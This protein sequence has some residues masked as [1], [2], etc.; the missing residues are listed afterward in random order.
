MRVLHIPS[1]ICQVPLKF[2]IKRTLCRTSLM[3][4]FLR[5][6]LPK[7]GTWVQSLVG[8]LRSSI[9]VGNANWYSHFGK[10][11]IRQFLICMHAKSLQSCLTLCN[12][13]RLLCSWDSPGRNTGVGCHFLLQIKRSKAVLT[14]AFSKL[15]RSPVICGFLGATSC[16][17]PNCQCRRHKKNEFDPWVGKIPWRM[18]WQAIPVFLP[19]KCHE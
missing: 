18:A 4:Q 16:K 12:P 19:G 14:E 2:I 3:V 1:N 7:Q 8:E 13:T 6:H 5:L 15:S 11:S 17:E 10:K 9:A